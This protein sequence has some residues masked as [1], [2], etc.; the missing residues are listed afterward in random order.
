[1]LLFTDP[2]AHR[3]WWQ[4]LLLRVPRVIVALV[5]LTCGIAA[6]ASGAW[7]I[8]DPPGYAQGERQVRARLDAAFRAIRA[9]TL[10][11]N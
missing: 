1:V 10:P 2:G 4:T 5:A 3:K 11:G 9:H 7:Q 8:A 6:M